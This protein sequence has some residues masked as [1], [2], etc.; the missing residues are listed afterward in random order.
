MYYVS[1]LFFFGFIYNLYVGDLIEAIGSLAIAIILA[2]WKCSWDF[3][4]GKKFLYRI[5]APSVIT[6]LV[7]GGSLWGIEIVEETEISAEKYLHLKEIRK[8]TPE[9]AKLIKDCMKDGKISVVEYYDIQEQ[10]WEIEKDK[11]KKVLRGE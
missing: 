4:K 3:S 1:L 11:S 8:S 2:S 10:Y 6:I 9:I 7:L 5:V